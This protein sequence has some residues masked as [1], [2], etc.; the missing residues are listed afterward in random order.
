MM[1]TLTPIAEAPLNIP[2]YLRLLRQS[3]PKVIETEE[4]NQRAIQSAEL[5]M[6]K[7]DRTPEESALLLLL[8]RLIDAFEREAYPMEKSTPR[9]TLQYLLDENGLRAADIAELMGGRP[10]A[11]MVLSGKRDISKEQARRLGERFKVSPTL[12]LY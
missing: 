11:S 8:T 1:T 7:Q 9:E 5:L 2:G 3:C 6:A 12:F 4:E 10:S